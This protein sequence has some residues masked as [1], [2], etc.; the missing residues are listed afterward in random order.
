M[1]GINLYGCPVDNEERELEIK[2][3]CLQSV[4]M[5]FTRNINR[6]QNSQCH[7]GI[8]EIQTCGEPAAG[9]IVEVYCTSAS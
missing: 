6:S 4:I 5:L 8:E 2:F 1:A 3:I 7:M 9:S